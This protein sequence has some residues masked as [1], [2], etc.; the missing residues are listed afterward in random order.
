MVTR[1]R[2]APMSP[3]IL[4]LTVFLWLLP[5][6]FFVAAFTLHRLFV[7]AALFLLFMYVWIWLWFR[8]TAFVVS[9]TDVEIIWPLRRRSIGRDTITNVRRIDRPELR[10]EVGWGM[11]VGAGGLWGGFGYLW[12]T[13]RGLVRLYVSRVDDLVWIERG[14]ETPWLI[15]PEQPDAFIRALAHP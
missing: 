11:R 9:S 12:T 6:A 5:V 4:V 1:F 2:L 7:L 3:V 13:R 10:S 14:R 15:T 8:P